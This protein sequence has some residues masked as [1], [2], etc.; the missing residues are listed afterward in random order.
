MSPETNNLL[1]LVTKTTK[2]ALDVLFFSDP[3]LTSMGA[4]LGVVMYEF[5]TFLFLT[6][7]SVTD[8]SFPSVSLIGCLAFGIVS[9]NARFLFGKRAEIPDKIR[10]L[11]DSIQA[12]KRAGISDEEIKN[13]YRILLQ[14][15]TQHALDDEDN[16][17]S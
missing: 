16:F 7:Q 1:D 2:Q 15:L 9:L 5:L 14:N 4:L 3:F 8:I 10:V 6:I 17:D 11:I 12:S 13:Q